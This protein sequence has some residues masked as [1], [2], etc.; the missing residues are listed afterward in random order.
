MRNF[1]V[2]YEIVCYL[3]LQM[4][5]LE[6]NIPCISPLTIQYCRVQ[7]RQYFVTSY[8]KADVHK[9]R[10]TNFVRW[11]LMYSYLWALSLEIAS[12]HP[13]GTKNFRWILDFYKIYASLVKNAQKTKIFRMFCA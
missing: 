1:Y 6:L 4:H 9:F 12:Y 7:Q 11:F 2:L 10:A 3:L 5:S 13:S 8:S